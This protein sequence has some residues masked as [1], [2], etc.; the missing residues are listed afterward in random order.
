MMKARRGKIINVSSV[1]GLQGNAGQASYAASKAGMLGLSKSL[2]RELAPRKICVNCIAPGYIETKMT[3]ALNDE[4]KEAIMGS[5]P[6]ARM[7]QVED[8]AEA[9]LFL[10]GK[11]GDYITGQTL[12]VDGGMVM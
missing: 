4:Q 1:V 12:V 8:I 9:A 11:S 7:G 5:I 10:A 3:A 2:A 6:L